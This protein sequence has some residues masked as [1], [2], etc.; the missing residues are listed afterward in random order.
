MPAICTPLTSLHHTHLCRCKPAWGLTLMLN[1]PMLLLNKAPAKALITRM[2]VS[3]ANS[4]GIRLNNIEEE[5]VMGA[6]LAA[7]DENV[8]THMKRVYF[9]AL[10]RIIGDRPRFPL[11]ALKPNTHA[12]SRAPVLNILSTYFT[13]AWGKKSVH[14]KL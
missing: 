2:K 7:G 8:S 1:K 10:D 9:A 14:R 5:R 4:V 6:M 12:P 13:A 11:P 3:M